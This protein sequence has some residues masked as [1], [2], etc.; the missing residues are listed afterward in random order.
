MY[1]PGSGSDISLSYK[2]LVFPALIAGAGY[3]T[4]TNNNNNN[5]TIA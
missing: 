3:D 2:I 5:N 1:C 4:I